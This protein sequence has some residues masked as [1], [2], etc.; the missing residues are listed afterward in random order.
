MLPFGF[1]FVFET[2]AVFLTLPEGPCRPDA[3]AGGGRLNLFLVAAMVEGLDGGGT[4]GG[5]ASVNGVLEEV[6]PGD[7]GR[8]T[9]GCFRESRGLRNMRVALADSAIVSATFLCLQSSS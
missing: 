3:D 2:A 8:P 9:S 5:T 1:G 7:G 4:E 6:V